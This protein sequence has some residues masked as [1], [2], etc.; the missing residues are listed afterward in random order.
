MKRG[1]YRSLT[2]KTKLEII[3]MVN[4]LPPGK[5]KD[6]AVEYDIPL[7]TLSTI[8]KC[9]DK[10][11]EKQ[12]L[13]SSKK[14]QHRDPT[15]SE[16]DASL[17]QWF[18]AARAIGQILEVHQEVGNTYDRFAVATSRGGSTVGHLPIEFSKLAWY[19]L[20]HGGHIV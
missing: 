11:Q 8:L 12:A 15:N 9:K 19:F 2:M 3:D 14:Q 16:V 17:F 4:N 20:H 7:S 13:G 5:R 10:L 18:T 1:K 6:I